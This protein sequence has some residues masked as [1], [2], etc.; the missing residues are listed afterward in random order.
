MGDATTDATAGPFRL[1]I[2]PAVTT[3]VMLQSSN[4][5][6]QRKY[7]IAWW[8]AWAVGPL[9]LAVLPVGTSL[10]FGVIYHDTGKF[11]WIVRKPPTK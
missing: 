8:L 3:A 1:N 9:L 6:H 11:K 7:W 4:V 2:A 10:Q 5:Q